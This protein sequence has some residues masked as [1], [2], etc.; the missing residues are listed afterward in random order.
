VLRTLGVLTATALATAL[1]ALPATAMTPPAVPV[2]DRG[3]PRALFFG[4][5]YF[6]GGGCSPDRTQDM[7]YLAGA[8]LGYRPTVRGAGGTGFVAANPEYDLPPYLAQ[9]RDGALDVKNPRLVVIAGG[10]N[11]VGFPVARIQ[12]NATKILHIARKK[13]PRATLV[14]VGP[15]DPYGGDADSLPIRDGL[16]AVAKK[17]DVPFV[18][19]LTWLQEHPDWLCDDYVHPTYAGQ[20]PLGQMLAKALRKRGA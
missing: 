8:S 17:V 20:V 19:D 18:D 6:V 3:Q 5:S 16:R 13:Y 11:D 7:A 4:D 15:M 14:L 9:I 12:E 10:S 1:L 2:T